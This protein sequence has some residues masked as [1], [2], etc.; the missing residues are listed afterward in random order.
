MSE[1]QDRPL[2]GPDTQTKP[3]AH[4]GGTYGQNDFSIS[5]QSSRHRTERRSDL[6]GE[7]MDRPVDQEPIP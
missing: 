6:P 5:A 7:A 2:A 3:A 4:A 1:P